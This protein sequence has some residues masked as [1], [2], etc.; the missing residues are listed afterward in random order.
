MSLKCRA[1]DLAVVIQDEPG[2]EANVGQMVE[3][4][5]ARADFPE[6]GHWWVISPL[7]R[8][9][10]LCLDPVTQETTWLPT[11]CTSILIEDPCLHPLRGLPKP[12]TVHAVEPTNHPVT[13]EI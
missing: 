3:V 12:K 1:G 7:G 8:S 4:L 6:A 2:C 9:E 5:R 13:K 10:W 11:A